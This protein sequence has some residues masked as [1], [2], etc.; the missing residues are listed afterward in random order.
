[1][2]GD[3]IKGEEGQTQFVLRPIGLRTW[4][5]PKSRWK[6]S[7]EQT[8][9]DALQAEGRANKQDLLVSFDP[10]TSK[11]RPLDTVTFFYITR[12]GTPGILYVGIEVQDDS[13]KTGDVSTGGDN[14]L[15]P[16][17]F[18]KGRRFGLN[19]LVTGANLFR[20]R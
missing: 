11:A 8:S 15:N 9:I 1:M 17:A 18:R 20:G 16:V 6:E 7:L 3:E 12:E 2:L 10:E 5:L 4:E 19:R 13:L 14:E